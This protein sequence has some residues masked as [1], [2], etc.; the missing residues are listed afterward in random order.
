MIQFVQINYVLVSKFTKIND[1]KPKDINCCL[2][3]LHIRLISAYSAYEKHINTKQ[4]FRINIH[5]KITTDNKIYK[6]KEE[7][8]L[9]QG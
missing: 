1:E 6:S 3:L 5:V 4:R 9:C 7:N 8:I 2:A